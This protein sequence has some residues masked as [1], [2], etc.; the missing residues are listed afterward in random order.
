VRSNNIVAKVGARMT[1]VESGETFV[2]VQTEE[3][4]GSHILIIDMI[5]EPGGGAKGAPMPTHFHPTQ[6]ERFYIQEGMME[7]VLNGITG[8][9][10]TGESL[11]VP[12]GAPHTWRNP[13]TDEKLLFRFEFE[14]ASGVEYVFENMAALSQMGKLRPD[15]SVPLLATFRTVYHYSGNLY[16]VG[17]PVWMQKLGIRAGAFVAWL[18]GYP[19]YHKY[20][21]AVRACTQLHNA[22]QA[23]WID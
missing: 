7:Y 9:I 10:H 5:C 19:L 15:G 11:V 23:A 2:F 18:L 22:Q 12:A 4:N 3:E 1:S 21:E 17:I 16:L 6:E 14:P 20:D 8:Y 13:S